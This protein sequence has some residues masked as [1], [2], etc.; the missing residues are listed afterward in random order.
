MFATLRDHCNKNRPQ[1]VTQCLQ[2]NPDLSV[3]EEDGI[4]IRLAIARNSSEIFE[5]LIQHFQNS[6]PEDR[7][8]PGHAAAMKQICDIFEEYVDFVDL[9]HEMQMTV[10]ILLPNIAESGLMEAVGVREPNGL[11]TI[12]ALYPILST[13]NKTLLQDL[14]KEAVSSE[15]DSVIDALAEMGGITN[16]QKAM[17]LCKAADLYSDYDNYE[18]TPLFY[19]KAM[20]ACHDYF[21][22]QLHYANYLQRQF[23]NEVAFSPENALEAES[24]YKTVTKHAPKYSCAHKK[25]GIL[26]Q[27]WSDTESEH[28]AD[29]TAAAALAKKAI[30]SYIMAIENKVKSLHYDSLYSE[31]EYLARKYGFHNLEKTLPNPITDHKLQALIEQIDRQGSSSAASAT[32]RPEDMYSV[33]EEDV[34]YEEFYMDDDLESLS[35]HQSAQVSDMTDEESLSG[36]LTN[37]GLSRS[38]STS[39]SKSA[40]AAAHDCLD[41]PPPPP[42]SV[43]GDRGYES[44]SD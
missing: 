18:K 15:K 40:S 21:I 20:V 13:T 33:A 10:A 5:T 12:M 1:K 36:L 25:L 26:Y 9:S 24:H 11:E 41:D 29:N 43:S 34:E 27:I 16:K 28:N 23:C 6:L 31:I 38:S 19:K 42:L 37:L 7:T 4:C 17:I 3:T 32:T 2:E 35:S 39:S 8:S 30:D 14:L 22:P 44:D